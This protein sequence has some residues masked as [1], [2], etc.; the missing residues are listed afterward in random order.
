MLDEPHEVSTAESEAV[1]SAVL[2]EAI[3]AERAA[4]SEAPDEGA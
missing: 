1:S 3:V 2:E 4:D